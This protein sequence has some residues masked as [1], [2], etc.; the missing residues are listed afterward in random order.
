MVKDRRRLGRFMW[1]A[2]GTVVGVMALVAA[3][4]WIYDNV[5]PWILWRTA[6]GFLI[7]VEVAYGLAL[8]AALGGVPAF[9]LALSRARKRGT[10]SRWAARG[11]ALC[12]SI[13]LALVLT[14][15]G[16]AVLPRQG[17]EA[18]AQPTPRAD[19]RAPA[20]ELLPRTHVPSEIA[21]PTTFSDPPGD[22]T[23]DIVVVGES[24]AAGVPYNFWRAR[25][26]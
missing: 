9:A 2:G 25:R 17:L 8:A 6:L 5:A 11:L 4:L 20:Q 3:S 24:S 16:A 14:E 12:V 26:S 10:R 18:A 21:L 7:A 22:E 19:G 15:A 23:V 13:L 1:L